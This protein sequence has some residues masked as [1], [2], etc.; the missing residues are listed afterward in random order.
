MIGRKACGSSLAAPL[1][2]DY[3]P[4]LK[5]RNAD[6]EGAASEDCAKRNTVPE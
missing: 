5:A 6:K 1:P 3:K 2:P 4:D